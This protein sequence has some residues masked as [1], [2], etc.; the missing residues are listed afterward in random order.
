MK[1]SGLDECGEASALSPFIQLI[2]NHPR[3]GTVWEKPSGLSDV[4]SIAHGFKNRILPPLGL[5]S[6][7]N[8]M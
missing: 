1:A 5:L 6:A 2:L 8:W 7:D 3:V 4:S